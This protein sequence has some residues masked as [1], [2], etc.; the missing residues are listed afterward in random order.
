MS[1]RLTQS[2][3]EAIIINYF[4]GKETPGY[5]VTQLSNGKYKVSCKP[6][7]I[8]EED[9]KDEPKK[10]SKKES[11]KEPIKQNVLE[12]LD[13]LSKSFEPDESSNV[14]SQLQHQ[15]IRSYRRK[16]LIL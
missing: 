14:S 9:I 16:R 15:P 7:E 4:K 6:I 1:R 5:E 11:K 10:E 2:E 8:E 12:S 3:R 13:S